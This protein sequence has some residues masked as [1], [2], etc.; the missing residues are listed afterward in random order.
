MQICQNLQNQADEYLH[1][2]AGANAHDR[3]IA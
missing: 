3:L 2:K 1:W